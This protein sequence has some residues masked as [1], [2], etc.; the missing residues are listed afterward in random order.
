MTADL[1]TVLA[2]AAAEFGL[3]ARPIGEIQKLY[4]KHKKF[5]SGRQIQTPVEIVNLLDKNFP[6]WIKLEVESSSQPATWLGASAKIV[7]PK[8]DEG[9]LQDGGFRYDKTRA[10]SLLDVPNLLRSPN[11]VHENL[12]NA[13]RGQGG[14]KGRYVYVEYYKGA[15]RKVGFTTL[16]ERLNMSVLVSSFW[17]NPLWV[18][19]CSASPAIYV[20]PGSTCKCCK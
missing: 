17:T 4:N 9:S 12:R 7:I 3:E 13:D 18:R 6:Y 15:R 20:R 1:Q 5:L 10:R 11:C 8:L 16:D 2:E 14:I 19:D